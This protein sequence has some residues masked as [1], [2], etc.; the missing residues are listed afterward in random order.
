MSVVVAMVGEVILEFVL[1][2]TTLL[3]DSRFMSTTSSLSW[4]WFWLRVREESSSSLVWL[5]AAA[6][7]P[8]ETIKPFWRGTFQINHLKSK[9]LRHS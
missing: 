1:P 8:A 9:I 6:R 2:G 3:R 5:F 7:D 4:A